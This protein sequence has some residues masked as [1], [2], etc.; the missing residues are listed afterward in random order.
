VNAVQHLYR[1]GG[2]ASRRQLLAVVSRRELDQALGAG[3][4]L[5]DAHGRYAVPVADVAVRTAS[6]LSG[7]ASHRSA[8]VHWG[9]A[10]KE[11]DAPPDV[12][13][14]RKR[15]VPT[16]RRTGVTLHWSDLSAADMDGPWTSPRRTLVDC[17]RSL[18]FDEALAIADSSLRAGSFDS[19]SLT[20]VA[21][22]ITGPGAGRAR[23]VARHADGRAANPFESVLRAIALDVPA[24]HFEPQVVVEES[25]LLRPDLVDRERRLVLEADSFAWHGNRRA[26]R[27]DCRR[28]NRLV[29]LGYTVLRFTWED[30]MR[31]PG[32]VLQTLKTL[33]D[34]QAQPRRTGRPAA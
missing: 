8:A 2:V 10:Q 27:R 9:W 7:V 13:V 1:L 21:D 33:V 24:L 17:L 15:R 29:L 12:T 16:E 6:A 11:P 18:P 5:R 22:A 3:T 14:P 31:D 28:Y 23:R 4:I 20:D 19:A 30:V 34:A 25:P 26:L 32:Y